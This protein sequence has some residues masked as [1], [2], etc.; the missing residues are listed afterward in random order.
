MKTKLEA[1]IEKYVPS[2][3]NKDDYNFNEIVD[4]IVSWTDEQ[5]IP[6]R[7]EVINRLKEM[8]LEAEVPVSNNKASLADIIKYDY[9]NQ[10]YWSNAGS[11]NTVIGQE[12]QNSY[13]PIQM[14]RLM[15][16]FANGGKK[17]KT[18]VI[19][20]IL[21]YDNKEITFENNPET[22]KTSFN[23]VNLQYV[24]DGMNMASKR[25]KTE[26][27]LKNYLL[28]L[29]IKPVQHKEAAPNPVTG[30]LYD[31]YAWTVAFAPYRNP[32]IA[33]ATV[34]F[35]GGAGAYCGPIV[36]DIVGQYIE[37]KKKKITKL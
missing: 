23:P 8:N 28:I 33:I 27:Y 5:D 6:S 7:T 3:K 16:I 9:L 14:A 2:N 13:T 22:E 19:D 36:R 21:T 20:K 24:L 29:V 32:E 30:E 12:G 15:A 34:I 17:V 1:E 31:N 18:S 11:L 26:I 4:K 35:Q 10:A 25:L 37:N